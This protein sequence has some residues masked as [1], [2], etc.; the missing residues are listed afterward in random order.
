MIKIEINNQQTIIKEL[1]RIYQLFSE[2]AQKTAEL[3]GY[4]QGELS[5]ALV[6]NQKIRDL[7]QRYRQVDCLTDVLSFSMDEEVW[8]DIIISV[9]MAIKQAAEYGHSLER[10]L[11]YL[12][13]HGILHLLG[14]DH[15]SPG[16]K[17][18]MRKKEERV[19]SELNL[20]RD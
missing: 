10:E 19:L 13:I 18:E 11:S 3:E 7:N 15:Q 6:D 17:E 5:F 12:A 4:D 16:E 9:E 14:Y 20:Y 1:E 8:G 2:I